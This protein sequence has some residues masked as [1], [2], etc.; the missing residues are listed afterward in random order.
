MPLDFK[1]ATDLFMGREEEL[2]MALRIDPDAV[3]RHR[4]QPAA[5]PSALLHSLADVLEE[6]GNAMVRVAEMLR[7]EA[8]AEPRGNG[9]SRA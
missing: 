2:A 5:V 9:R 3:R 1:S 7:E 4:S 6:R 8:G